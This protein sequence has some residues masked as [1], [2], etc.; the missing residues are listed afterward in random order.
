MT[1]FPS[2]G[3]HYSYENEAQFRSALEAVLSPVA[4]TAGII[5]AGVQTGTFVLDWRVGSFVRFDMGGDL[6]LDV[7]EATAQ[8][9]MSL[10]IQIINENG[11]TRNLTLSGVDT[12]V[13]G[14]PAAT[15][16][17]DRCTTVR[18]TVLEDLAGNAVRIV[19]EVLLSDV[20]WT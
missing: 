9:G 8:A 10:T 14:A 3:P 16:Q 19:G 17:D 13:G 12:W 11:A 2:P 6:T 4:P 18:L 15:L 1:T 7:D 5:H 20:A